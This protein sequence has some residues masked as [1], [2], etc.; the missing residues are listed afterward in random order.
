MQFKS[1]KAVALATTAVMALSFPINSQAA[2][3]ATVNAV[4]EAMPALNVIKVSNM[5]FGRW[6]LTH[7]GAGG[8]IVL[9]MDTAGNVT[10]T[11]GGTSAAIEI[12]TNAST[13]GR[14]DVL[15]PVGLNAYALDMTVAAIVDF[16]DAAYTLSDLTYTTATQAGQN[17]ITADGTTVHPVTV[18]TGGV[19]EIVNFGGTITVTATPTPGVD[20]DGAFTATFAY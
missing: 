9:L 7:D 3:N 8:D 12:D 20:S 15:L 19:P 18:V 6:I 4:I 2:D 10:P 11:A 13:A 14:L 5:D 17:A 1:L 16:A